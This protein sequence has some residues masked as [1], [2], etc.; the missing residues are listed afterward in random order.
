VNDEIS[1]TA[2]KIPAR[3]TSISTSAGGHG[4]VLARSRK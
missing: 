3:G 4:D 2:V 1:S